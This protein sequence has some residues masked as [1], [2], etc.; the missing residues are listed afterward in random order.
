MNSHQLRDV[1]A[2]VLDIGLI[3]SPTWWFK[4]IYD[5]MCN[6]SKTTF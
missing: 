3:C 1:F 6:D 4:A 2:I 5:A